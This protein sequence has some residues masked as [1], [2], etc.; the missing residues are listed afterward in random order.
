MKKIRFDYS[1]AIDFIGEHELENM[2]PMMEIAHELLHGKKGAGSEYTG[3]VE[4]P[5]MISTEELK[6]IKATAEE[7]KKKCDA[8]IVVGIGGSYLGSKSAIE[9]LN[10]HFYNFLPKE[11]R[12]APQIYFAGHHISS[13]YLTHLMEI[14]KEKDICINVISKSGTTTEPALAFRVLKNLLEKKYG[15]EEARRRIIA[16]TDKK[17]GAL[18]TLADEEGY[19]T[20]EIPDDIGG[21]FSVLTPVGL[22]PISVAGIEI[23]EII[24]G[25]KDSMMDSNEADLQNNYCYQYAVIRNI[26]FNKGKN[27]EML[28]NYEPSLQFF[29]E[30]WK[31]LFGESEGKDLKGIFPA[32]VNFSTDLHSMGQYIQQGMRSIFETVLRVEKPI[33]D[34]VIDEEEQDLDGLNYLA[35]KTMDFVNQKAFEGTILA[36]LDGGVP[37]LIIDIPE[38]SPYYYGYLVYYFE[39]ACGISAYLLGVNPFDQPGVEDYKRNMF[40]LLGKQGYEE[41]REALLNRLK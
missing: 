2:K 27:I 29:G 32:T 23:S 12:K 30:W 31:Q 38:L 22:L 34:I 1:K 17:K 5:K 24:R 18:K 4:L 40:A 13:T 20:F 7:I 36:H 10:H 8:F 9:M 33:K 14:I 3:W 25:A 6:D 39:K 15:K 37:N 19:K 21:R 11:K 26:L 28:V 35:G 41:E 16:T